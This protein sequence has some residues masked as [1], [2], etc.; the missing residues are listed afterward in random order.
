MRD[1]NY[2]LQRDWQ[3][4][5]P[6]NPHRVSAADERS[7]STLAHLSAFL[8]LVTGFL[9][10]VAALVIW[11][12]YRDRSSVVAANAMRSVVYQCTW[13]VGLFVGWSVTVFLMAFLVGF[14]LLP[15]MAILSVAFF[16]QAGYEAYRAY[17]GEGLPTLH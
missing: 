17:K 2:G 1:D 10:P 15:V 3:P 13:L 5:S 16:V 14:L 12:A 9:G 4:S 8:N 11:L 6:T 7:W